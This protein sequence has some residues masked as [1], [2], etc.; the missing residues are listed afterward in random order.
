MHPSNDSPDDTTRPNIAAPEGEAARAAGN[1]EMGFA[2]GRGTPMTAPDPQVE[3]AR[4]AIA[5]GADT[6]ENRGIRP[7][8]L[9]LLG[10][11]IAAVVS[12][13]VYAIIWAENLR[14]RNE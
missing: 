8:S 9:I 14:R 1:G 2:T 12:I 3:A 10:L 13:G 7:R 6:F 11:V 5:K 4:D